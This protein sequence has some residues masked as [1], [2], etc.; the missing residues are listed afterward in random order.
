[1]ASL[2]VERGGKLELKNAFFDVLMDGQRPKE[3]KKHLFPNID[4]FSSKYG[5]FFGVFP[6][7]LWF[8]MKMIGEKLF[9]T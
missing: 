9:H 1:M 6:G 7:F 2:G 4:S 5:D 8:S 3:A